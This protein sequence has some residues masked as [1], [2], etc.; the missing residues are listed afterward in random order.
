MEDI[1]NKPSFTLDD[2]ASIAGEH[3]GIFGVATALPGERDQN[4]KITA[5]VGEFVI[6]I[7]NPKP[8]FDSIKLVF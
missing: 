3:F 2:A 4:F 5:Q 7:S 6:K 1:R 8:S